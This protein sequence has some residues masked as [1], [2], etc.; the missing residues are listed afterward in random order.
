MEG[1]SQSSHRHGWDVNL[2]A[3]EYNSEIARSYI[4]MLFLIIYQIHKRTTILDSIYLS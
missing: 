4:S 2:S 1:I 3:A